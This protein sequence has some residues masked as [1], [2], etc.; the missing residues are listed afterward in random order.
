MP[1]H[2]NVM[3]FRASLSVLGDGF[4]EAIANNTLEAIR[5][6]AAASIAWTAHQRAGARDARAT[7]VGRF[8][9]KNQQASLVSFSADA[10][11]NEM[12][13]T[14]PLQPDEPTS[15]GRSGR[16][17]TIGAGRPRRRRRRGRRAVRAVHAVDQGAAAG[18]RARRHRGR[19]GRR[20]HLQRDRLRDCHTREIV[21]A[22]P[23]T[24]I[25]GGA[26]KVAERAGQQDHSSVRRLPAARHRDRRRHR[27]ERRAATRNKM[28][29]APL[30]GLRARGRFMHD[31]LSFELA[32]A[33]LRHGN[34]ARSARGNF[35]AL[36]QRSKDKLLAFLMSL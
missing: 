27:P 5:A 4:V 1:A 19:E 35:N 6:A 15:N 17:I 10:Y 2:T 33:I 34:Q 9:W 28:R 12:G 32:D 11:V 36:S 7:R 24:L 29:T 16:A 22:A 13:I 3:A 31:G 23:G 21:T 8:G 26:L 14:S 18:P 30:W 25:N 20:E